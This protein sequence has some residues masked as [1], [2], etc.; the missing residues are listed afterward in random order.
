MPGAGAG[1]QNPITSSSGTFPMFVASAYVPPPE[2]VTPVLTTQY[3]PGGRWAGGG[4]SVTGGVAPALIPGAPL[5][6]DVVA[7]NLARYR[8]S[9]S[10]P[11]SQHAA[12]RSSFLSAFNTGLGSPIRSVAGAAPVPGVGVTPISDTRG[13]G[14]AIAGIQGFLSSPLGLLAIGGGLLLL[15]FGMKRRRRGR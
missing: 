6:G 10:A 13:T 8:A 7:Y 15:I 3:P 9:L 12:G 4:A 2:R 11:M 5:P 1:Y 14:N